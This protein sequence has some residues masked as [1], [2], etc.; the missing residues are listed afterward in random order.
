V[1]GNRPE[2]MGPGSSL[3]V[4]AFNFPERRSVNRLA[5]PHADGYLTG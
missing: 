2:R 4:A 5:D 3:A 1:N